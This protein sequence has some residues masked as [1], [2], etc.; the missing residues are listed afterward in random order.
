MGFDINKAYINHS[1]VKTTVVK[2]EYMYQYKYPRP[3][4]AVDILLF[5][6]ISSQPQVLLIQR[7]E[8]PFAGKY[9]LP[10]G[11]INIDEPLETAAYRELKEETGLSGIPLKQLHAFGKPGRDPRGRVI[12]VVFWGIVPDTVDS[13]PQAHSDAAQAGWYPLN[14]LPP[15]AFDHA[16]I[17][18][19]ARQAGILQ[20]L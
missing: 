5:K 20:F 4:I 6:N 1:T 19:Y 3:A 9:A 18:A 12:S 11:F 8:N 10:G 16:E 17:I 14:M 15:L 7:A 13:C 2:Y